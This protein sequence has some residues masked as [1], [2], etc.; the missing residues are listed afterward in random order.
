[1]SLGRAAVMG[2]ANGAVV[3][4]AFAAF[5]PDLIAGLYEASAAKVPA[6]EVWAIVV[7][8]TGSSLA[9]VM[10]G[11]NVADV[12]DR[13]ASAV[14]EA[15]ATG[16]PLFAGVKAQ[17]WPTDP[18]AR[19]WQACLAIREHRGDG[20]TAVYVSDGFDPVRMNILTEL[21][22]GYSLGEYSATRAWGPDRTEAA[23][24]SLT[25]DGLV[26]G[27]ALTAEG[28]A[29]RAEI[30]ART[31]ATQNDLV[32]ALGSDFGDLATTLD[33][34][35]ARCIDARMFPPDPRKRAAG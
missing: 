1:M 3:A 24:Q 32:A 25:A 14:D 16:R 12:S 18:Y 26:N 35:S 11:E 28:R 20:H 5:E 33:Q 8:A 19:L 22:L 30:E 21:W 27:G 29:L 15:D 17:P 13:L 2:S 7:S 23:L 9:G 10:A 34:W 31:D 6:A 4:S